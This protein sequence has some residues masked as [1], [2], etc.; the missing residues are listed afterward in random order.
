MLPALGAPALEGA[1][2]PTDE[3]L[4][5]LGFA[6]GVTLMLQDDNA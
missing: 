5:E 3:T 6:G 1:L 2:L 4:H